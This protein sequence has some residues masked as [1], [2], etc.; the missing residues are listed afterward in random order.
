MVAGG[1]APN[2]PIEG[3]LLAVELGAFELAGAPNKGFGASTGLGADGAPNRP[4]L[5]AEAAGV[6][7]LVVGIEACG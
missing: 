6:V 3:A 2:K 1:L 7:E 5:G 4:V